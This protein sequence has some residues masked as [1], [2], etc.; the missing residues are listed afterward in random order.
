[1]RLRGIVFALAA[2]AGLLLSTGCR[3]SMPHSCTWPVSGDQIPT[4]PKPPEGGYYTNW[5]PYAATIEVMPVEDV[6]PVGTQHIFV[7]TVKDKDGKPLPN[8]RVE[9]MLSDG[10][11]SFVEVDESGVRASR[12]Y[13]VDN[14]FAVTHTNNGAHTLTRGTANT[15]DDVRLTRGQTWAVITSP[16]EGTTH[17][18]AYAPGIHDWTKHKVFVK[19]HWQ[20]VAWEFPP[21]AK[22]P[23]GTPHN[24]ATKVTTYSDRKPLEGYEVTYKLLSGPAGGF[25]PDGKP[26]I[27]VKT[28]ADGVAVATLKQATPAEGVNQIAIDVIRPANEKCCLPAV[29]IA[30]GK[31]SKTWIGPKIAITKTAPPTALVG[32]SFDYKIVVS[33]PSQVPATNAVLVDKLPEGIQYVSS[34]PEAKVNGQTLT[35]QLGTVSPGQSVPA[36][37]TVKGT[38]TGEFINPARVTADMGLQANAQAKT[39]ITQASLKMTKTAPAEALICEPITYTVTVTNTGDAPATNVKLKDNLPNGLLYQGKQSTLTSNF[40]T[41][42][43]GASKKLQ[44]VVTASR[45]G[46][47]TNSAKVTADHGLT[48]TAKTKTVVRQ[49]VLAVV[50]HAPKMRYIGRNITYTITVS[51]KGDGVAK[52]CVVM[53]SVPAGCAFVTAS[54]G[55]KPNAG[56]LSWNLG[57]LA[58][59]A[60]KKVTFTVKPQGIG[61]IDNLAT[62]SAMCAKGSAKAVT[63][64]RGISAILLECV[65]APDPIEVGSLET[66]T[67]TVTNQG[68]AVGTNIV[69]KCTLPAEQRFIS[70]IAPTKE[71]AEG[72]TIT[73][74][75][76]KSLA[77]KAK[78]T[79]KIVIKALKAGDVRFA[80]SLTSDQLKTPVDETESTHQYA[81]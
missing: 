11:G 39:V 47:Y 46:A 34:R 67:I 30:T 36:K 73:F 53:D 66:Y 42:A 9:W 71:V 62:V 26:T 50:K 13:K 37:V 81:D 16:I 31:T 64:V 44:Y 49:P 25:A 4:H 52:N 35:W 65:D 22:N 10:V 29:H 7:A 69:I 23:V 14:R 76:L 33:N 38:R 58:P 60:S 21:A 45:T 41:L 80:V 79:Y 48:A 17:V 75:P 32:Q 12:G 55:I 24:L 68:T 6:N 27:K 51:N 77:P 43:P 54:G 74:A 78:A 28:N 2:L 20:D 15:T 70:A 5:D 56:K 61:N 18:I 8:R 19:K 72:Q 57:N 63:A 3:N 40:G 1:M 59:E